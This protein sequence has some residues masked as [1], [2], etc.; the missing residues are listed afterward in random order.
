MASRDTFPRISKVTQK[1][2]RRDSEFRWADVLKATS[3]LV[4]YD[5]DLR[6]A[7]HAM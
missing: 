1:T 7:C 6:V 5:G 4:V 2:T 3:G